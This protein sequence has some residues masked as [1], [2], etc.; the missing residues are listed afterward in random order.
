MGAVKS[1]KHKTLVQHIDWELPL[2]VPLQ[3][4]RILLPQF[5]PTSKTKTT[6]KIKTISWSKDDIKNK[7]D[8]PI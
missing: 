8:L 1:Q 2:Q 3:T 5:D 4:N 6:S 7:S